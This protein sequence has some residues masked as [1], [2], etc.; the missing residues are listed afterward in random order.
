MDCRP[1]LPSG[2]EPGHL[3]A[4]LQASADTDRRRIIECNHDATSGWFS[5]FHDGDEIIV[6]TVLADG[7]CRHHRQQIVTF[8]VLCE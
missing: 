7:R 2:P 1:R 5:V 3:F 4:N 6:G 8:P